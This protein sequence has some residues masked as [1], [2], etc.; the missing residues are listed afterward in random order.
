[1]SFSISQQSHQFIQDVHPKNGDHRIKDARLL[2]LHRKPKMKSYHVLKHPLEWNFDLPISRNYL[3][4]S[5]NLTS[6]E[7]IRKPKSRPKCAFFDR[8]NPFLVDK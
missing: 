8:G 6:N 2:K 5:S 1:M 4:Q 3:D 7:S